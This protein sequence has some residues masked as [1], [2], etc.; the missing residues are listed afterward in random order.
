MRNT[1]LARANAVGIAV[2]VLI[3]GRL[4]IAKHAHDTREP[5]WMSR[6]GITGAAELSEVK[7]LY[8]KF[9]AHVSIKRPRPSNLS[10]GRGRHETI[11]VKTRRTFAPKHG[12][13]FCPIRREPNGHP[14]AK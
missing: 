13:G 9:M 3:I 1:Y 5:V 4:S 12:T 10:A 7:R 14:V 8:A 6:I 11:H 2:G